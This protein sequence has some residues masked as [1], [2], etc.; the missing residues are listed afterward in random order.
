MNLE[1]V[2]VPWD[3]DVFHCFVIL[4]EQLSLRA[5]LIDDKWLSSCR[6]DVCVALQ[7][8]EVL[9]MCCHERMQICCH[10]I[11]GLNDIGVGGSSV[12]E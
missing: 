12:P 1:L 11:E 10:V 5:S 2:G 6:K 7:R 8:C 9:S 4:A 3:P